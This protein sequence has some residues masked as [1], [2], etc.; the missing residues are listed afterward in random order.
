MNNKNEMLKH[1]QMLRMETKA[2]LNRLRFLQ[3]QT[4]KNFESEIDRLLERLTY[5]DKVEKKLKN[6]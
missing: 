6:K 4:G 5:L 2:N 1:L 3:E